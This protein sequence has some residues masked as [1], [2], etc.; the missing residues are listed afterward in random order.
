MYSQFIFAEVRVSNI[1]AQ[2]ISRIIIVLRTSYIWL[3]F[4]NIL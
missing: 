4:H 1:I 2:F 3:T